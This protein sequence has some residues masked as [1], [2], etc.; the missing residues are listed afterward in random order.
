[1]QAEQIAAERVLAAAESPAIRTVDELRALIEQI[2]VRAALNEADAASKKRLYEALGVRL[3]F[4]PVRRIVRAEVDP[5]GRAKFVS[6]GGLEP[7]PGIN[8]TRPST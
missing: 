2:D 4:D 5:Q 1:M 7:P 6:E 8:R 3:T